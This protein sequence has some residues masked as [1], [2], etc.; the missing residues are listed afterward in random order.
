MD[1]PAWHILDVG[2]EQLAREDRDCL[3][4]GRTKN[5]AS[6]LCQ[7]VLRQSLHEILLPEPACPVSR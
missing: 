1:R 4:S 7:H 3:V 2:L 5:D 6:P